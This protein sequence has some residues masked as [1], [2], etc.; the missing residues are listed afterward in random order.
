VRRTRFA[1][2]RARKRGDD[3]RLS[4]PPALVGRT[5]CAASTTGDHRRTS[6]TSFESRAT[7]P[8]V[9]PHPIPRF[10]PA[11]SAMGRVE[12]WGFP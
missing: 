8:E 11:W 4:C 9:A 3:R 7:R 5:I 1:M 10:S 2:P 6:P 12:V